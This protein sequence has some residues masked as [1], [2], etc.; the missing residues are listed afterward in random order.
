MRN[1]H[2]RETYWF[3]ASC[4]HLSGGQG[5]NLKPRL[6][7]LTGNWTHDLSV[8]RLVL[9]PLRRMGQGIIAFLS[10]TG[11]VALGKELSSHTVPSV[12][13][14]PGCVQNGYIFKLDV[15]DGL[16]LLTDTWP[17]L[18]DLQS[19]LWG[20]CTAIEPGSFQCRN[21]TWEGARHCQGCNRKSERWGDR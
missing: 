17:L 18:E 15:G 4:T 16:S 14:P 9:Y 19:C 20:C 1:I 11:P 13:L 8:C 3:V 2:V 6:V 7:T 10:I 21:P 12:W 5:L